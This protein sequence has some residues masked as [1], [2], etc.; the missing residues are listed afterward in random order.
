MYFAHNIY[1]YIFFLY[2]YIY[3]NIVIYIYIYIIYVFAFT[4]VS[5]VGRSTRA[6]GHGPV[7]D[8][9]GHKTRETRRVSRHVPLGGS[10]YWLFPIVYST[11]DRALFNTNRVL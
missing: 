10:T 5:N 4:A 1:I 9:A 6:P 7:M 8:K 3:I 11:I 2:I